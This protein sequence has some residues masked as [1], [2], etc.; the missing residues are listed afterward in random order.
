MTLNWVEVA[1]TIIGIAAVAL[2]FFAVRGVSD[3]MNLHAGDER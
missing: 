2:I 1:E 3:V